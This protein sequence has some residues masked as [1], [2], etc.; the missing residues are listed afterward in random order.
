MRF[1]D[2]LL[3][4]S[5]NRGLAALL[6]LALFAASAPQAATPPITITTGVPGNMSRVGDGYAWTDSLGRLRSALLAR[7]ISTGG[8]VLDRY[9]YRLA[10]SSTR[11]V[12]STASGAGG[13]GYVVSHLPYIDDCVANPNTQFCASI[14]AIGDDS[15]LG[16]NFTGTYSVKFAGRHHAIHEFKTTYPRF[17]GPHPAA[18]T[19]IR[20]DVPV[21]IQWLFI[22]GH[23]H[24]LWSVTWDWSAVPASLPL[25]QQIE[26]DSRGPYGE[27]DFD[28]T[29]N[30]ANVIAG[31]AWAVNA[32]RF[33]TT[34]AP[35]TLNSAWT[36][37]STGDAAIPFNM[38]WIQGG[39]AQ[40]GVVQTSLL[41]THDAG[42]GGYEGDFQGVDSPAGSRCPDAPGYRMFCV[43]DWPFQ[44][45]ENNFYDG[46][47]A[48]SAISN[49]NG[50]RLAWGAKLGAIGRASYSN[51]VNA[52][53]AQAQATAPLLCSA[54]TARA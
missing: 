10:N 46:S 18:P 5:F 36:W 50:R 6:A 44:S 38:L 4:T 2:L 41:A 16:L 23:D 52:A 53:V 25:A 19:F 26:G 47:G 17:T 31:V 20:Y 1:D 28:G 29:S 34:I 9:A 49:T 30:S 54:N 45:I 24:P 42:N 8:G 13:F 22:N 15:P 27:M 7:N 32:K 11:T 33:T 21:T 51:Y 43:W 40:M 12:N 14:R 35:F 3:S 48:L 37:S 39:N